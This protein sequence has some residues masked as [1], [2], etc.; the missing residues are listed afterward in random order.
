MRARSWWIAAALAVSTVAAAEPKPKPV[1]IKPFRD[2]L[3]VLQ[4][5][6]GGVY[7]VV[8]GSDGKLFYGAGGKNKNVYEQTIIGRSSDGSTGAWD[9]SVWAPRVSNFQPG[10][11]ARKADGTFS[12]FCGWKNETGLSEITGDKAKA[13]I[14]KSTFLTTALTRRPYLLARD[15]TGVYYYVD[16][17]REQYGGKGHRVFI[18]KKGALKSRPLTDVTSD[19]AGDVFATKT[20]DLRIVRDVSDGKQNVHWI[21]GNKRIPLVYLDTEANAPLIYKDLGIYGFIGS[22]CE[23]L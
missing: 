9:V 18:G 6:D 20:G 3:I 11:V 12:R 1:D 8:P 21:K 13:I 2:K 7:I 5:A 19:T 15:D 4:D 23:N 14:D 22:I 17:L 16:V 10:N